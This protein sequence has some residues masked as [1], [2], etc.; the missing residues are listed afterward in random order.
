MFDFAIVGAGSAGGVLA[1][2]LSSDGKRKVVLLEA[3]PPQHHA[4]KVRAPGMY[5]TLWR[6]PL[7]WAF[8]TEPQPTCDDRRHFWPRGKVLGGTSCL[9]AMVYIRGN[10]A[11]Y[12]SW[13]A[14][15]SYA[16]V[17]PLFRKSE[18][19]ARGESEY[20][21]AGGPLAVGDS[22]VSPVGKAFVAA[23]AAHCKVRITDDFNGAEQEGVGAYQHTIRNGVRASTAVAFLDSIRARDNL[24]VITGALATALVV[25]GDRVTGVRYRTAGAEQ[26]IE[27]R[28]VI[29]AG[30]AIG[31]PHLLLFS[32]LG[33]AD[34]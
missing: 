14:G 34:G 23:A 26:V 3:G 5:N 6:T 24:T 16:D 13:G 12:D 1:N 7:D 11:N 27:A 19:N 10:R 8:S 30:G 21:G 25:D 9:N 31:S 2:R 20:H 4:F 29:V 15:W 18:D 32:G 28:E 17:L 33:P 22:R